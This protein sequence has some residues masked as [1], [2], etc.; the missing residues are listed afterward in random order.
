MPFSTFKWYLP[1][2]HKLFN[3]N[4]RVVQNPEGDDSY[5]PSWHFHVGN[6]VPPKSTI[7][8]VGL[9]SAKRKD[10]EWYDMYRK[11]KLMNKHSHLL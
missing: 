8:C 7:V 2:A 3:S 5:F 4:D 9:R 10:R 11:L 1:L 6:K